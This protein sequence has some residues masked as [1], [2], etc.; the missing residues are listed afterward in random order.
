MSDKTQKEMTRELYQAVMGLKDNPE[1]NGLIGD[2]CDIKEL[3][4]KQNGR[5]RK[6]ENKISWIVGVGTGLGLVTIILS[7]LAFLFGG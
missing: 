1:D 5:V 2:I 4:Q 3:L 6:N 7:V